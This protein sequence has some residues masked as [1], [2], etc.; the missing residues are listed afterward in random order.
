MLTSLMVRAVLGSALAAPP[1]GYLVLVEPGAEDAYLPAANAMAQLH[2]GQVARCNI[3]DE[4]ALLAMLKERQP[5]WV[6]FVLP[7]ERIDV[8]V[9]HRLLEVATQVDDDPFVDFEYAFITGRDGDA[10]LRFVERINAAK[11]REYGR[12][13]GFFG[14]WEGP[15]VPQVQSAGGATKALKLDAAAHLVGVGESD[16]ARAEK[17]RAAFAEFAGRDALLFFSHGYPDQ[18]VSCFTAPDLRQW[19]VDLGGAILINCACY[20]GAPGRWWEP[21]FANGEYVDRGVIDP[22]KS[23]ALAIIDSGVAGYFGGIDPWHG[24]LANQVFLLVIDDGMRVGEAA[25]RMHDRLAMAFAPQR[26]DYAPMSERQWTGEGVNNRL[27]NGAGMIVY[28]DP[29]FAPFAETATRLVSTQTALDGDSKLQCTIT[30]KPLLDGAM[31]AVDGMLPQAR[32]MDYYSVRTQDVLKEL[33]MEIHRVIP[34]P[35][36][37]TGVESVAVESCASRGK[38]VPTSACQWMIEDTLDGRR[39]Q[40]R[41]PIDAPMFGSTWQNWIARHGLEAKVTI[42]RKQ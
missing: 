8:Q 4:A 18:M 11:Q 14:S 1:G 30:I 10:A 3:D 31:N 9:A 15:V 29:A 33:K 16:E 40:L 34:L 25:K 41:V 19:K 23:V 12:R 20:N 39:L 17:A 36:D 7:P 32:L 26:I 38:D 6:V 37:W 5:R 27:G 42:A 28:G 22:Q 2:G 35:A 13:L 21:N 24:P